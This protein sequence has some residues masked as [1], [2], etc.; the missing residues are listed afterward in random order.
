MVYGLQQQERNV[1]SKSHTFCFT[2]AT[3]GCVDFF[4]LFFLLTLFNEFVMLFSAVENV[5]A[6]AYWLHRHGRC[7][8]PY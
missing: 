7:A 3:F 4:F 2:S 1:F 5:A 6:Y 8:L